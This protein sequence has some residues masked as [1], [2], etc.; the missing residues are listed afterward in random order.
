MEAGVLPLSG[1]L[2]PYKQSCSLY[3]EAD[4]KENYTAYF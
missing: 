3:L 2:A 1:L 4:V